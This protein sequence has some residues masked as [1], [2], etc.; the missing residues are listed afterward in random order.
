MSA[1]IRT[2]ERDGV[3]VACGYVGLALPQCSSGRKCDVGAPDPQGP[4]C[5]PGGDKDQPCLEG[6][7]CSYDGMFCDTS[8]T[9][10]LCGTPGQPCCP[11]QPL[12]GG[13]V[14]K[15]CGGFSNL[16]C[17]NFN[18]RRVCQ[19]MPGQAPGSGN[20]PPP[21][22][23]QPKTCGG[24]PQQLGV[25]STFPIWVR[26]STGCAVIGTAHQANSFNEAVQCARTVYGDTVIT[27]N[28]EQYTFSMDGP[29]GC[30]SVQVY[31]KD[32]ED[33]SSCAQYQC[34]NCSEPVTGTCP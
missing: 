27:E 7:L 10:R 6:R 20:P 1:G 14:T 4:N 15:E 13:G 3:C 19:Y 11:N 24:Q 21:P 29:L 26:E 23:A 18:G 5:I 8:N 2:M 31:G 32:E 16:H 17:A 33:A 28:V 30:R 34:V 22:P 12:L 9:C 25:T